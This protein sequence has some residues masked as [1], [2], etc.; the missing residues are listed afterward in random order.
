[1]GSEVLTRQVSVFLENKSGRLAEV[2]RILAQANINIRGLCVAETSDFGILRLIVSDPEQA[3][4]SLKASGFAVGEAH[5]L[6]LEVQ[7]KPGG[8]AGVLEKL[9]EA[10][11]NVEYMYAMVTTAASEAVV[12][13]RVVDEQIEATLRILEA[14]NVHVLPS[15]HV[16]SL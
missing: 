7:D 4:A 15:E 1:M 8:L 14:N 5:V 11:I 6:A 3:V 16:Y 9:D 13:F 12:L 2:C 10:E